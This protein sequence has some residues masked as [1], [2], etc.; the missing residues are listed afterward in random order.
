MGNYLIPANTKKSLLIFGIFNVF[1]LVLFGIGL[2]VSGL[3]LITLPI[4]DVVMSIIAILPG[5]VTGFLIMPVPNYHNM[6]TVLKNC[7]EFFTN[8]QKFVWRGWCILDE[9]EP[10]E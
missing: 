1:D 8:N 10:K 2:A 4:S 7:F 6:M 3:L 5:L 9:Q